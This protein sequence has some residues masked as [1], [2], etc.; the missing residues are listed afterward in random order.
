MRTSPR[1][2]LWYVVAMEWLLET[3]CA[4]AICEGRRFRMA[5]CRRRRR[6]R[7]KMKATTDTTIAMISRTGG[8]RWPSLNEGGG[9]LVGFV[10][11]SLGLL[12]L[13][14]AIRDDSLAGVSFVAIEA[15]TW[16][17]KDDDFP[18]GRGFG[19]LDM[20]ADVRL[21][22]MEE[23]NET[24]IGISGRLSTDSTPRDDAEDRLD[25]TKS[26]EL[27]CSGASVDE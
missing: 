22:V 27:V 10:K 11:D 1:C 25:V 19:V 8:D 15:V 12:C 3:S 14:D 13:V 17:R 7:T 16:L 18:V 4:M 2:A 6:E 5:R 9:V 24:G 23:D 20:A 26:N 21:P